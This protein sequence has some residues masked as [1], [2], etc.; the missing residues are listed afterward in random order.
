[1]STKG[2]IF[3]TK[4]N[5]HCYDETLERDGDSFRLYLEIDKKNI[6]YFVDGDDYMEIGI[7][8]NSDLSKY[9]RRGMYER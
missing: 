5:E 6:K 9:L 1:M 2:T 4:D 8:G 7:K 3:L